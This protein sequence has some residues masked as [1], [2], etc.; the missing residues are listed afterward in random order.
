MILKYT[1]REFW[2]TDTVV[3]KRTNRSGSHTTVVRRPRRT[4]IGLGILEAL[5]LVLENKSNV[6]LLAYHS[7]RIMV[8]VR[9]CSI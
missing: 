6:G 2:F 9:V 3:A 1:K 5:V 4:R 7:E 8:H